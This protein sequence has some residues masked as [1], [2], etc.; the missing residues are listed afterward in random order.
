MKTVSTFIVL[1]TMRDEIATE[2]RA[3][4]LITL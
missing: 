4:E 3:P 1:M 2:K